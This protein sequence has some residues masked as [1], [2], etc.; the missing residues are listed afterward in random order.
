MACGGHPPRI[1]F[2]DDHVVVVD[3]PSGM[4]SVPA[5]TPFDPPDVAR[6][7]AAGVLAGAIAPEAVHRLDRDTSGLLVL[8]RTALAR[9]T[10]GGA[11]ERREVKKSYLAVVVGRPPVPAGTIHLP[12]GADPASAPRQRV[13]PIHGRVATSRWWTIASG[14]PTAEQTF[15]GLEPVTGR[16]H[17]L[18]AHLAWLGCP[19]AGDRLYCRAATASVGRL[20]LH[21]GRIAFPHPADGRTVELVAPLCLESSGGPG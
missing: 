20:W 9:R 7:L 17:Q 2:L 5:R 6:V 4:P 12:L 15:L 13:D 8:A 3:K 18:R 11:F 19:V 10:L 14:W 16:S 21:A 1:L